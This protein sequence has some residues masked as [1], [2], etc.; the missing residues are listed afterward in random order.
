M[1]CHFLV[2]CELVI[3]VCLISQG[4]QNKLIYSTQNTIKEINLRSGNVSVLLSNLRSNIYSLD[5]DY[6]TEYIYFPRHNLNVISRFRYPAGKPYIVENVI[7]AAEP[8]ALV[9]DPLDE[10]V[11][12]TELYTGKICKC[13][14]NGL[15]KACILQDDKLYAITLDYRSRWL[16][17]TTFGTTRKI[18]RARLNGSDKQTVI[19]SVEVTGLGIDTNGWRLYWMVHNIGELRSSTLNGTNIIKVLN[20]NKTQTSIGI[21]VHNS[22][23]YCT[24]GLQLLKV[25]AMPVKAAYVLHTDT[26]TTHGVLLYD[27]IR[28]IFLTLLKQI[29]VPIMS[30][31]HEC[32]PFDFFI[33]HIGKDN[34]SCL[35]FTHLLKQEEYNCC[36]NLY[37]TPDLEI[38]D[39]LA[40]MITDS[41]Y[42]IIWISSENDYSNSWLDW[43]IDI[44]RHTSASRH[45]Y[46]LPYIFRLNNSKVPADLKQYEAYELSSDFPWKMQEILDYLKRGPT[47]GEKTKS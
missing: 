23:I 33:I 35:T 46:F 27:D 31:V 45:G 43:C 25:T 7:T 34:Q 11:F 14:F 29:V 4:L 3:L 30:Y 17:Y 40:Q 19:N 12:W 22:N 26:A 38:Q 6:K 42:Y 37:L 47:K 41:K 28:C 21:Y 5:Y 32:F 18:R 36:S 20:T 24:N 39:K 16:Y 13:N 15:N 44:V 1:T 8:I 9:I 10:Y 2:L